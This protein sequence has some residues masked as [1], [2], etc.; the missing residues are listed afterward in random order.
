M[1]C[2][3]YCT[4]QTSNISVAH[5]IAAEP[6]TQKRVLDANL[7]RFDLLTRQRSLGAKKQRKLSVEKEEEEDQQG[8]RCH[9]VQYLSKPMGSGPCSPVPFYDALA[10]LPS[11]MSEGFNHQ[12]LKNKANKANIHKEIR[13]R[14]LIPERNHLVDGRDRAVSKSL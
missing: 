8:P 14:S 10:F 7:P 12:G 11:F 6:Y 13:S 3:G 5:Y 9:T 2:C 4:Y 1:R